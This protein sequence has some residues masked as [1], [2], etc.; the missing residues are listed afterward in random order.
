MTETVTVR[1]AQGGLRGKKQT[2]KTGVTYYSFQ[3]I[4]Y[5]E[6]PVGHLRFKVQLDSFCDD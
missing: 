3:G 4:P 5:A 1:V 2:A 6:P